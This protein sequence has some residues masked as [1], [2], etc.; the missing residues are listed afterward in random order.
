MMYCANHYE[1]KN[2]FQYGGIVP[3]ISIFSHRK[4]KLASHEEREE[5]KTN[6]QL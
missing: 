4:N 2:R 5:E 3:Y 1:T 6:K